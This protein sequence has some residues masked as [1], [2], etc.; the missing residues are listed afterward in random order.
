MP[1]SLSEAE[2]DEEEKVRRESSRGSE[3]QIEQTKEDN[4]DEDEEEDEISDS[5]DNSDSPSDKPVT[6]EDMIKQLKETKPSTDIKTP[7][8]MV[9]NLDCSRYCTLRLQVRRLLSYSEYSF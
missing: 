2:S 8:K 7:E 6:V 5:D 1:G 9:R 4:D 3:M